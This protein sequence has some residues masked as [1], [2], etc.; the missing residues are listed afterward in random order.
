VSGEVISVCC[1]SVKAV[2]TMF[3]YL[4]VVTLEVSK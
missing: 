1:N 2:L 4:P 3:T